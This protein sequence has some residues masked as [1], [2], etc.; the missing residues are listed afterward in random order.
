MHILTEK[1]TENIPAGLAL[2][3]YVICSVF[4]LRGSDVFC[5]VFNFSLLLR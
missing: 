3:S 1:L 4:V 2:M 5:N